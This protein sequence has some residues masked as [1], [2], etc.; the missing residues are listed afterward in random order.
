MKNFKFVL[1]LVVSLALTVIYTPVFGAGQKHGEESGHD[2]HGHDDHGHGEESGKQDDHEGDDDHADEHGDHD[3][4]GHEEG[5]IELS[6]ESEKL[7]GIETIE[8]K[9][10]GFSAKVPVSGRIAQD[11]EDVKYVFAPGSAA[12]DEC[13]AVLSEFIEQG[14]VLCTVTLNDHHETIKVRAP[15]SGTVISEFVKKGEHVDETTAL[16]AI[17]DLTQLW[18]NFDVYE[19]DIAAIK[20]GQKINVYPLAYPGKTL[21]GKIVFVSHR[22]DETTF[23]VKI[24][25]RVSNK[26]N[27]L[28]LGMSV[29]GDILVDSE[30]DG[31]TIPSESI[32]TVEG[33]SVVFVRAKGGFEAKEVKVQSRSKENASI[34]AGLMSGDEVVV[35]G[36]FSL[37]S[38]ML[39]SEM[40][41]DHSH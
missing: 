16:Y 1:S 29:R 37:K 39:E 30:K 11:V 27:L 18:A 10:S 14:A 36:S 15:V 41:H 20:L 13:H 31:I 19:K 26:K 12:V 22:V 33:R 21:K 5:L 35:K 34:Q 40:G 25:A 6:E 23:T 4:H 38:K 8:V 24:R 7:A 2:H 9:S 28:K 17:A 3:E 32:Q